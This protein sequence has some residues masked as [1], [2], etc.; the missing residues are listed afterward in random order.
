M[1]LVFFLTDSDQVSL[2]TDCLQALG[3]MQRL[4]TPQLHNSVLWQ[5]RVLH[6]H[7]H[8]KDPRI[9]P[10][11][12]TQLLGSNERKHWTSA[13]SCQ[14][15]TVSCVGLTM[16]QV[17][18]GSTRDTRLW[19]LAGAP[20]SCRV[21]STHPPSLSLSLFRGLAHAGDCAKQRYC[22]YVHYSEVKIKGLL[23]YK[24]TLLNYYF[25]FV[26]T[27]YIRWTMYSGNFNTP[28]TNT[29]RKTSHLHSIVSFFL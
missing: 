19:R 15:H 1:K 29:S 24:L 10:F 16:A 6:H 11:Q 22:W 2:W 14:G 21:P 13:T 28:S 27:S 7:Q 9:W 12:R 26:A 5:L 3:R 23:K 17:C 4:P 25:I 8:H 18:S 20:S